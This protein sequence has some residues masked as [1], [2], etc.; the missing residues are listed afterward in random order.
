M[1]NA[2]IEELDTVVL[3]RDLPESGLQRGDV[4][5]VVL[6]SA[7]GPAMRLSSSATTGKQSPSSL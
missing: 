4:G 1:E 3:T 7:E 2:M 5:A 6:I